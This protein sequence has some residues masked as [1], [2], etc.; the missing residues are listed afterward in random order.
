MAVVRIN[1]TTDYTVM[2]NAHFR[3]KE[4]SLKAKGLLSMMLSLPDDWDY[5]IAGLMTLSK[6]GKDSVMG[7]LNELEQFGYLVRTRTTDEKGRFTGY[8]YDIY[9]TPQTA[10]PKEEKPYAENPNTDKPNAGNPP[11][12]STNVLNTQQSNTQQPSTDKKVRKQGSFDTLID[13]YCQGDVELKELLG[14]WLKVRK[15]KRAAMTDY[16]I[17]LNLKKLDGIA[18]ASNMSQADYLKEVIGRGWAAFYEIKTYGA[19]Q[20]PQKQPHDTDNI[21]L[22]MLQDE[23]ELGGLK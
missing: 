12:L 10:N 8:D 19:Q 22:Q 23:D 2:S 20:Q 7:A 14:E 17:E 13:E 9:E 18:A 1:K 3:E 16:A 15:A 11:Q 5:S 6:D 21:F 4:M